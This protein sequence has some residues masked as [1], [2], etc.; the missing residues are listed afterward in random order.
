MFLDI[1]SMFLTKKKVYTY[2]E[3]LCPVGGENITKLN[4]R[5]FFLVG[6]HFSSSEE[7]SIVKYSECAL[8]CADDEEP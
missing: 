7:S 5:F 3:D 1:F 8:T 2:R 6:P 4:G